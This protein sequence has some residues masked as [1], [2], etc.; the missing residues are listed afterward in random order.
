MEQLQ[1][2]SEEAFER[3]AEAQ[4]AALARL[5]Y[6]LTGH[7]EAALDLV[8]DVLLE[9]FRQWPKVS[10]ARSQP[11]YVRRMLVNRHLNRDRRRRIEEVA[12]AGNP[13]LVAADRQGP[14]PDQVHADRDAMWHALAT[15]PNRQRTVLV[16]R[17]YEG[18]DDAE[19]AETVGCRRTT[20][21]S[22]A[23]RGLSALRTDPNLQH[24]AEPDRRS[25]R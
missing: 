22:L 6:Q 15:L 7:R 10:A 17:Y 20:V 23:A 18:L 9:A 4:A 21:R 12:G 11:A 24:P 19:I 16:L 5:A 25:M 2:V 8:Q 1:A 14:P 13:D 3:F